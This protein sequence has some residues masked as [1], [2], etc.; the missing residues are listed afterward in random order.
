MS[1]IR[2]ASDICFSVVF[3]LGSKNTIEPAALAVSASSKMPLDTRSKKKTSLF[4]ESVV[5][6]A[7]LSL[8]TGAKLGKCRLQ[9]GQRHEKRCTFAPSD[10]S[11]F[12]WTMIGVRAVG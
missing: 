12:V 1:A 2:N 8:R 10:D 9:F 11:L 4:N 7:A 6:L 3:A 5:S